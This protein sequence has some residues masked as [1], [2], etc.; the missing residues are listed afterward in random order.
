MITRFIAADRFYYVIIISAAAAMFYVFVFRNVRRGAS[1]PDLSLSRV[2]GA[3]V[4]RTG[5]SSEGSTT[6]SSSSGDRLARPCA[7]PACARSGPCG[8][9]PDPDGT[10]HERGTSHG[11]G[12]TLT[13]TDDDDGSGPGS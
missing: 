7:R 9:W 1:E 3:P 10:S 5:W 2:H 12:R 4:E 8:A 13:A 11:D 6:C